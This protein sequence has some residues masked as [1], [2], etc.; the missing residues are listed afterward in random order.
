VTSN[1][2][3][4]PH[5]LPPFAN[6]VHHDALEVNSNILE[7]G[8]SGQ[9]PPPGNMISIPFDQS[10]NYHSKEDIMVDEQKFNPFKRQN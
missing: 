7:I 8:N 4:R 1:L 3:K 10:S 9:T 6:D 2:I 5:I